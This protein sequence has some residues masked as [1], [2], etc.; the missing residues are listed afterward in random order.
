MGMT[1]CTHRNRSWETVW[2]S[3]GVSVLTDTWVRKSSFTAGMFTVGYTNCP[4]AVLIS[5]FLHILP[6]ES[7]CFSIKTTLYGER[8]G[9]LKLLLLTLMLKLARKLLPIDSFCKI[10]F[11]W[12]MQVSKTISFSNSLKQS[13]FLLVFVLLHSAQR[14]S[15]DINVR[16]VYMNY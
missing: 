7:Q 13:L 14:H 4:N 15:C 12:P 9:M 1:L 6:N 11:Y 8:M 16:C 10:F 3:W 5:I 2:M